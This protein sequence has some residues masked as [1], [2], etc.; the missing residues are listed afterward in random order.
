[1]GYKKYWFPAKKYGWGWSAPNC[2]Q[3]W[4]V[5]VIW[6]LCLVGGGLLLVQKH[7]VVFIVYAII[8]GLA[9]FLIC[10]LKGEKLRWRWGKDES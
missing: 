2:W 1:M 5:F 10:M 7:L 8:L 6:M 9:L 4:V 3:G